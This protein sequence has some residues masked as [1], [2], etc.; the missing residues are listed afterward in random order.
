MLH[1]VMRN[2]QPQ[3]F[4]VSNPIIKFPARFRRR[5]FCCSFRGPAIKLNLTKARMNFIIK[6]SSA[7]DNQFEFNRRR[8]KTL[9]TINYY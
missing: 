6:T 1:Q 8:Y 2:N 9:A 5:L 4:S 7:E 3:F